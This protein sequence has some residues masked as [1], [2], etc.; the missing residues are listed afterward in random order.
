MMKDPENA[1]LTLDWLS[2]GVVVATIVQWLP[3]IA[4][5]AS[6][7]YTVIR[8]YESDTGK[9]AIRL[10][11]RTLSCIRSIPRRVWRWLAS[12]A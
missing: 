5:L 1:K 11:M 12:L 8:I 3:A 2:A 4:A 9:R 6:L 10:A 7:V